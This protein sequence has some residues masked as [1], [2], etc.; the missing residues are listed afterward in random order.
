MQHCYF[1]VVFK[2]NYQ[3]IK[4][5][6]VHLEVSKLISQCKLNNRVAQLQLY[7]TYNQAMYIIALRYVKHAAEAEDIVQEAF[8]SAFKNLHQYQEKVTF[9]AWLKRIVI[10]K[11]IDA[12]KKQK[13]QLETLDESYFLIKENNE[14]QPLYIKEDAT[15]ESVKKAISALP[16][17]Y[18]CIINL[19]LIEGYD[20]EEIS[21]ILNISNVSSRTLLSRGKNKLK[22]I[23]NE[24]SYG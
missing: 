7:N 9:G 3:P 17:K 2:A 12:L 19:Y 16:E 1:L 10:N 14:E 22:D 6:N 4:T 24:K 21:T 20:H 15:I 5:N 8:I 18:Q 13:L 23:L 11:C